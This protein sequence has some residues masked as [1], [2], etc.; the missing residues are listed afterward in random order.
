[1][2]E[3]GKGYST[4][5]ILHST[6]YTAFYQIGQLPAQAF[7]EQ[8][9]GHRR[10]PFEVDALADVDGEDAQQVAQV[11]RMAE[12]PLGTAVGKLTRGKGQREVHGDNLHHGENTGNQKRER[13]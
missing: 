7:R 3:G 11:V 10:E 6:F 9:I 13:V 8:L 12:E 4:F 2:G 5:Y 1:M